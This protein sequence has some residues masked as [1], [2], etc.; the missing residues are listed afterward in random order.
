M[1]KAPDISALTTTVTTHL[2]MALR[3]EF[4]RFSAEHEDPSRIAVGVGTANHPRGSLILGP[5]A[6]GQQY[7]SE[8]LTF[9]D[10]VAAQLAGHLE[11]FEARASAQLAAAAELRAIRAQINPHFLFN[12]LNTLADMADGQPETERTILNLSRVFRYALEST[13]QER[14]PLGTEIEAVRA[15]LEIEAA[16]FEDQVRFAITIPDELLDAPVP[17]MLLQPLV[18]N[19]VTHGLSAKIDGGT[20]RIDAVQNNGHLCLT[21]QDDGVGFEV[22]HTPQRIGLANV[23][24]RVERTGGTWHV[25]SIPGS[26]TLI[27]LMVATS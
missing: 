3:A 5:R 27:T 6:R 19:A 17:P 2:A 9:V 1:A 23:V 15:Y 26:G 11:A 7:G 12:A 13:H 14:V 18:E 22:D 20:V 4:V 25:Q 24:A 10:A 16:R 21:V 8:D